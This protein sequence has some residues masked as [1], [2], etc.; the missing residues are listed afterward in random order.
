MFCLGMLGSGRRFGAKSLAELN[1]PPLKGSVFP[2]KGVCPSASETWPLLCCSH[3]ASQTSPSFW[4]QCSG[5][6]WIHLEPELCPLLQKLSG[7]CTDRHVGSDVSCGRKIGNVPCS[8]SELGA[9]TQTLTTQWAAGASCC[10]KL[11][12]STAPDNS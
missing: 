12:A 7:K 2:P 3:L 1:L 9:H 10:R 11:A 4:W 5:S 8:C 6:C